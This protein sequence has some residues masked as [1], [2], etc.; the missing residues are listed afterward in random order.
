MAMGAHPTGSRGGRQPGGVHAVP[1]RRY[2]GRVVPARPPPGYVLMSEDTSYDVELRLLAAIRSLSDVERVER[3]GMLG[4]LVES[5]ARAALR[6]EHPGADEA[7]LRR[8]MFVREFGVEPELLVRRVGPSGP[9][10]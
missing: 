3:V 5:V 6:A 1:G 4:R 7:T 10:A 9:E 2:A 8:L